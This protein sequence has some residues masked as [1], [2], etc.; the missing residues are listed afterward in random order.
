[1]LALDQT[2]LAAQIFPD[3]AKNQGGNKIG[4]NAVLYRREK[5]EKTEFFAGSKQFGEF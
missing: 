3:K 5:K 4:K 1:L 2:A